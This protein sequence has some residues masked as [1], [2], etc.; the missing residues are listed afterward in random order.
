M[1]G[2]SVKIVGIAV[3]NIGPPHLVYHLSRQFS[4]LAAA[5]R[6]VIMGMQPVIRI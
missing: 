3:D 4:S 5:D 6:T 1:R 2:A